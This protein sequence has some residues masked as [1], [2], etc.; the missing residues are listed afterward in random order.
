MLRRVKEDKLQI[1]GH[2]ICEEI[3]LK[4]R[5]DMLDSSFEFKQEYECHIFYDYVG[6]QYLFVFDLGVVVFWNIPDSDQKLTL[7]NLDKVLINKFPAEEFEKDFMLFSSKLVENP[8]LEANT[9]FLTAA[10]WTR[11]SHIPT[12]W[13]SL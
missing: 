13:H 6:T 2:S 10:N 4:V 1:T 3:N 8:K 5:V 12:D 7:N 9:I 11:S